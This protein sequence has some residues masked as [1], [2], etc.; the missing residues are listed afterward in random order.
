[1]KHDLKTFRCSCT[2][3][4]QWKPLHSC[5]ITNMSTEH[6][7]SSLTLELPFTHWYALVKV[8]EFESALTTIFMYTSI[9]LVLKHSLCAV[10]SLWLVSGTN[11][12]LHTLRIYSLKHRINTS[13][14][15]DREVGTSLTKNYVKFLSI[16]WWGWWL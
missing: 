6:I 14:K 3:Q 16:I 5:N 13:W 1:M 12:R 9:Y 2:N 7:F 15:C 8:T 4:R 10:S 11:L